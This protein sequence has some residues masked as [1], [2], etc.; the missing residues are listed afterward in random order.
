MPGLC[1]TVGRA[2]TRGRNDRMPAS[3]MW[4]SVNERSLE[5][6]KCRIMRAHFMPIISRR[7]RDMRAVLLYILLLSGWSHSAAQA[8]VFER[9]LANGL[10]VE[11]GR[12][13]CRERG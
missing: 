13:S 2:L 3:I 8:E 5:V 6:S 7:V 11:I 12:A 4:L 1:T 9:T 10:K